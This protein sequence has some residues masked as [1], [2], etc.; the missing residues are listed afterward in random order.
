MEDEKKN[1]WRRW[2]EADDIER[3]KMIR[4]LPAFQR[5]GICRYMTATLMNSYLVDL[6]KEMKP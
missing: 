1:F 6:Y 2:V 3:L 4:T 5:G